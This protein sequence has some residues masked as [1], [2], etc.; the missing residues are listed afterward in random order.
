MLLA[1][2]DQGYVFTNSKGIGK[3]F[4][5]YY[6]WLFTTSSPSN[7]ETC[8]TT[9]IEKITLAMN[10][11]LLKPFIRD[12][13]ETTLYQIGSFKALGYD[14]YGACFYQDHQS[15]VGEDV[16]QVVLS[17]LNVEANRADIDYT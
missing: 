17:F 14:G 5:E 7:I 8:I 4:I 1:M 16:C 9:L 13:I 10:T 3:A 11:E 12:E 2:D 15:I 6:Q